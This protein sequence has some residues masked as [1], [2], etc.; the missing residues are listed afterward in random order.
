MDGGFSV[1]GLMPVQN[2]QCSKTPVARFTLELLQFH[3]LV[4][5]DVFRQRLLPFE[6]LLALV[7]LERPMSGGFVILDVPNVQIPLAILFRTLRTA[8]EA[9]FIF[10]IIHRLLRCPFVR[11]DMLLQTA[12]ICTAQ[13]TR[14]ALKRSLSSML[15]SDAV[16]SGAILAY[17]RFVTFG[18]LVNAVFSNHQVNLECLILMFF[19]FLEMLLKG[20]VKSELLLTKLAL[21]AVLGL[22]F[23]RF[24]FFL[25]H[26]AWIDTFFGI[27]RLFCCHAFGS[28]VLVDFFSGLNPP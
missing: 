5:L 27:W 16:F 13:I 18:A 24:R 21:E 9:I 12:A 3:S 20:S 7:A 14:F 23:G 11:L 25:C 10:W 26:L 1:S 22:F 19:M 2:P 8:V 28:V 6:P 15:V 17:E 4:T